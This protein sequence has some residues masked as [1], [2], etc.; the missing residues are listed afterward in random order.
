[1]SE[2][3]A[4]NPHGLSTPELT[5]NWALNAGRGNHPHEYS[6]IAQKTRLSTELM[7]TRAQVSKL[8]EHVQQGRGN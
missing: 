7:V 3:T 6:A 8:E 5:V 4:N 1:M 2:N